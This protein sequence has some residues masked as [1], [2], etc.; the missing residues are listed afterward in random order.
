MSEHPSAAL[1]AGYLSTLEDASASTRRQRSWA[2][3]ELLDVASESPATSHA[4]AVLDPTLVATWMAAADAP[5]RAASL[6]GLRARASAVRALARYAEDTRAAAPGTADGLAAALSLPAP[7]PSGPPDAARVRR[8]LSAAHPDTP[9]PGVLPA[10]W[11]RFCA[12]VHLLALTGAGED[13]LAALPTAAVTGSAITITSPGQ[14]AR[15]ALPHP[16]QLALSA[17]LPH[18]AAV[19]AT[20]RGS[21]PD[22][23][24]LRVRPSADHRTGALRPAGLPLSARGL[25]LAFTTTV[26]LLQLSSPALAGVTTAEVRKLPQADPE[27]LP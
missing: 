14:A 16:A 18:R 1:V 8:L 15:W 22:A 17:W 10:V 19:A 20:L 13:V 7:I 9:V 12:H 4:L 11:A 23:L 2:L 3:R 27:L 24:W 6:P 5:P 25:R 26:A 21:D